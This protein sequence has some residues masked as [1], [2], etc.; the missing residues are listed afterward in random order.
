MLCPGNGS[1]PIEC[2][3]RGYITGSGWKDYQT[4]VA[5]V[6]SNA[7]GFGE[8]DRLDQPLF[9][10][11]TKAEAG[12]HD[13]NISFEQGVAMLASKPCSGLKKRPFRFTEPL[14]IMH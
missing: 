5:Y 10:P 11:S 4:P 13:E 8:S 12:L 3:A 7:A 2:I 6:A 14:E 9:T 1:G